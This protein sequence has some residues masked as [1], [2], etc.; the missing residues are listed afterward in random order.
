MSITLD[1]DFQNDHDIWT[2]TA[3]TVHPGNGGVVRR[4]VNTVNTANK[5]DA[6]SDAASPAYRTPSAGALL[7]PNIDY[8]GTNDL[9]TGPALSTF[10]TANEFDILIAFETDTNGSN[11]AN[12]WENTAILTDASGFF[13]MIVKNGNAMAYNY[14][15]NSDTVSIAISTGT[16]YVARMRHDG[17]TLYLSINGGAESSI[18]SGNTGSLAGSIRIG[19]NGGGAHMFNGKI[20]AIVVANTGDELASRY[21]DMVA[22]WVTGVA[23]IETPDPLTVGAA[24][25]TPTIKRNSK[26]SALLVPATIATPTVQRTVRPSP[27][28]TAIT[29]TA[30]TMRRIV[31]CDPL[32]IS[33]AVIA[34]TSGAIQ[35]PDPLAMSLAIASPVV[36]RIIKPS[37]LSV[38][39]SIAPPTGVD[40]A[41]PGAYVRIGLGLCIGL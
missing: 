15:S 6:V 28:A 12:A 14:D 33:L 3:E 4:I 26:P 19:A 34:P 5:F 41:I 9:H 21:S 35:T 1:V 17:G 37:P 2:S 11:N 25:A 31:R 10:I 40:T 16:A 29:L 30:P 22:D 36:R 8:D 24:L 32:V 39:L 20:G 27:L 13:G 23:L 38:A 7:L 18:A